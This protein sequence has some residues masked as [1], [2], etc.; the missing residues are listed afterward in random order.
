VEQSLV[1]VPA[2]NKIDLPQAGMRTAALILEW[3]W[4]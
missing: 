2:L 4:W 3:L 1:V